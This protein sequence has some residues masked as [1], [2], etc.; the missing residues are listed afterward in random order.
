MSLVFVLISSYAGAT[1]AVSPVLEKQTKVKYDPGKFVYIS[2]QEIIPE[3]VRRNS[4]AISDY[5]QSQMSLEQIKLEEGI[6]EPTLQSSLTRQ[7]THIPNSS[8]DILTRQQETYFENVSELDIGV[9]GLVSSG[10]YWDLKFV[11]RQRNSSTIQKFQ[12]YHYEYDSALKLS[13]GQPLLKGFGKEITEVKV[14]IAKIQSGIDNKKYD[15][16]LMELVGVTIQVYWKLYGAEKISQSWEKS[17][18]IAEDVIKDI[19]SR[20]LGGKIA[21][22][23]LMEAQS[24]ISER[25]SEFLNAKSKVIEAQT[26]LM[27][28]LNVAALNNK[29]IQIMAADNPFGSYAKILAPGE[30]VKIALAK[31]PKYNIAKQMVE[32]ERVQVKYSKNQLLPQL[33]IL[34]DIGINTLD[35]HYERALSDVSKAE[36]ISWSIGLK[37]SMPLFNKTQARSALSIAKMRLNQANNELDALKKSLGNSIHNKTDLLINLQEQ[38]KEYEKGL[39]IRAALLDIERLKLKSGFIGFKDLLKQEEDYVKYQRK[40]LSAVVNYKLTEASLEIALG[41]ILEKYHVDAKAGHSSEVML[42]EGIKRIFN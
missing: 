3:V 28:L 19:E 41:N 27:T 36:Y 23:V 5:L 26:Q 11:D 31:W 2:L 37:F 15:Q 25:R 42:P 8:E 33:D 35:K 16:K 34:G 30:A 9:N 39:K 29:G 24:S 20:S 32:K 4:D 1:P 14:N 7:R 22:T 40:V 17:L 6:Y 18:F 12:D 38:L 10:A 21:K 13:M